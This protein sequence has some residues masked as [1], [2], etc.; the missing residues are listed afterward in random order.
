MTFTPK[1]PSRPEGEQRGSTWANFAES[2]FRHVGADVERRGERLR[3]E[4]TREQMHQVEGRPP[5]LFG[6]EWA[7]GGPPPDER[8]T[9]RLA[10]VEPAEGERE[11]EEGTQLCVPGSFRGRQLIDAAVRLWPV[12]RTFVGPAPR[13]PADV[14]A[15]GDAW[16]WRPFT[17]F[18]FQL[19]YVGT[20]VFRRSA[21]VAVDLVSGETEPD[22]VLHRRRDLVRMRP[23]AA[24][25]GAALRIW[26]RIPTESPRVSVGAAG[27]R[28]LERLQ[29]DLSSE[30]VGWAEAQRRRVEEDAERLRAYLRRAELEENRDALRDVRAARLAEL[31][32]RRPRVEAHLGALTVVYVLT[33]AP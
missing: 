33:P 26:Q 11:D 20:G 25:D 24:D 31:D 9:W 2:L 27:E 13:P 18:H 14:G 17:E 23:P 12:G 16:R 1:A 15:E 7:W 3:V 8:V 21:T 4:M 19:A 30:D 28:A 5:S 22:C 10:L 6:W 29:A 32:R